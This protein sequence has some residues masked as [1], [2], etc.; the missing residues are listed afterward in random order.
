M[1]NFTPTPS[2]PTPSR[3]SR[4]L[5][6]Y[7]PHS[8]YKTPPSPQIHTPKYTPNPPS[9]PK[10]R[11]YNMNILRIFTYF[12][13]IFGF[14]LYCGFEGGF[15]VHF[16]IHFEVRRGFVSPPVARK[17]RRR[18]HCN[19]TVTYLPVNDNPENHHARLPEVIWAMISQPDLLSGPD[20]L[21]TPPPRPDLD[22]ILTRKGRF[23]G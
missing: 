9:K 7:V 18:L 6:S 19:V 8:K 16:R 5:R 21:R 10:D 15:G 4:L 23:Q 14:F 3:T 20:P 12:L 2:A 1:G 17:L 11:K 13:C 22:P